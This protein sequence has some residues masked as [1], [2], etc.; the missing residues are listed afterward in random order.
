MYTFYWSDDPQIIPSILKG[1]HIKT[2]LGNTTTDGLRQGWRTF[3][4][5]RAQ[6]FY[7][8]RKKLCPRAHGNFEDQN[9][10]LESS[11]IIVLLLL[12]LLLLLMHIIINA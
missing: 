10:V 3:L 2:R 12:L 1:F 4:T 8:F 5:E 9:K 6:N 11:I 7:K